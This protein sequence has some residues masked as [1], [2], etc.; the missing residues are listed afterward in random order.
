MPEQNIRTH[1]FDNG[2]TLVVET[3]EHVQ[4]AAFSLLVPA[5]SIYDAKGKN[6][7]ASV[8]ANLIPRGAGDRNARELSSAL[9]NLGLQ[10][11]EGP[12]LTHMSFSGATLASNLSAALPIYCDIVL[13][14]HLPKAEFE[15]ARA[16]VVQSLR[17]LED[18]PRQKIFLELRR[19]CYDAPWGLPTE[20][21]LEDVEALTADD[22]RAHYETTFR[23]DNSILGVAGNVDFDEVRETVGQVFGEWQSKPEPTF[24][25]APHGA[26]HD[27]IHHDS[28]QTQ[29]GIAYEAVPY[30][31]PDYYAGWAAVSVLSGG[32]SSRLFTEV[33]EK[34]GLCYTIHA[35]LSS[36]RDDARV[37]CYAGTTNERAQ[38]TLDTTMV[39]LKRLGDGIEEEELTRCKARA[40]SSLI[41]QQESTMSRAGSIARDW[42]HLGE[43]R[44]LD[45]VSDR[46]DKLTVETVLDYVHNHPAQDFTILTIGPQPLELPE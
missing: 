46:I 7:T 28:A 42:H 38:E 3:M 17:A 22:I 27:H 40:K 30:R 36:L 24:A 10:R 16:G 5:G 26:P 39:E 12:G 11:N 25:T 37:L 1:Q 19:R 8:L 35:S 33:R 9:D 13:R 21:T 32:M 41:M 45:D 34:K 29:I 4:S 18:E 2:L 43:V 20:G 6:G 14:P 23:P 15:A 31:S 44:T